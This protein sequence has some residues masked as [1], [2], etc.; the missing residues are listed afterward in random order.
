MQICGA[1]QEAGAAAGEGRASLG[2][3]RWGRRRLAGG[4]VWPPVRRRGGVRLWPPV[5]R[6]GGVR[7]WPETE[8]AEQRRK[9]TEVEGD[10]DTHVPH[11]SGRG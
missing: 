6:R 5:R 1:V 4:R 10:P 2:G 3:A 11:T 9:K 7:L 8:I